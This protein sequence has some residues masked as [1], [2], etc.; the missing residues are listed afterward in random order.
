MS[1]WPRQGCA[2]QQRSRAMALALQSWNL[3]RRDRRSAFTVGRADRR[4]PTPVGTSPRNRPY[5]AAAINDVRPEEIMQRH[6]EGMYEPREWP[7]HEQQ[8]ANKRVNLER[9]RCFSH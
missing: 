2:W 4:P 7:N 3:P 6:S 1:M 5:I 8:H 9:K